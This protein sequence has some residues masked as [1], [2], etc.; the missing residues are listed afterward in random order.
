[1]TPEERARHYAHS[2]KPVDL[3]SA[4]GIAVIAQAIRDAEQR[5]AAEITQEWQLVFATLATSVTECLETVTEIVLKPKTGHPFYWGQ[6]S[7]L[8]T[9]RRMADDDARRYGVE[10]S[11]D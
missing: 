8:Q 1:M 4:E 10:T 11:D 6:M 9:L 2:V 5:G 3:G 7:L